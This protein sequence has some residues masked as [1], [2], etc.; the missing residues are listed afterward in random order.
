MKNV[1]F[2]IVLSM[3]AAIPLVNASA[4]DLPIGNQSSPKA[5]LKNSVKE[6]A[7][8]LSR[9]IELLLKTGEDDQLTENLSP[10]IGLTGTPRTKG[11]DFTLPRP[12]GKE[13]REC[14]IVFSD[15]SQDATPGEK[16]PS[17][18]YI[19]HK[20]VSGHDGE[21]HYYRLN[22]E[23]KLEKASVLQYKYD[24]DGKP[25][26][27]SGVTVDKDITSPAIQKAFK[28]EY[29]YWT[30]EWVKA[31]KKTQARAA[32]TPPASAAP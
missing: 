27:G 8:D 17:C 26:A 12:H 9:L 16:R 30:K 11:R 28:A 22:L 5:T 21:S 19:Q 18:L 10:V 14:S 24:D 29:A 2:A 6:R 15:E 4:E 23:G 7:S 13:R 25:I 31:E 20:I 1:I 32:A 3:T